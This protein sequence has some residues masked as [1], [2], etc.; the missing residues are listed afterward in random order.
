[1]LSSVIGRGHGN[2]PGYFLHSD[3]RSA[4]RK[5]GNIELEGMVTDIDMVVVRDL[6]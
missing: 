5:N 2:K 6:G 3:I 1:M 4:V